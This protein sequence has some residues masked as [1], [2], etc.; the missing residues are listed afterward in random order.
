[1]NFAS[2][3][4]GSFTGTG[5]GWCPLH[6]L[7]LFSTLQWVSLV[8]SKELLFPIQ[9]FFQ[10]QWIL[11]VCLKCPLLGLEKPVQSLKGKEMS[12]KK[13]KSF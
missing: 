1:M 4:A 7:I 10:R 2:G 5:L 13:K 11:F 8:L 9:G 3:M 6:T 12:E